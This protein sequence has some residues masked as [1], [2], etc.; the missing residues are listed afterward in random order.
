[1]QEKRKLQSEPGLYTLKRAYELLIEGITPWVALGNFMNDFYG[2]F[3]EKRQELIDEPIVVP[4]NATEEQ[5]R[6]AVFFAASA[7]YHANKYNLQIPEWCQDSMYTEVKEEWVMSVRPSPSEAIR[8]R[9]KNTSPEEFRRRKIY[10]GSRVFA[11]KYEQAV[12]KS[13]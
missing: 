1:M 2:Y 7:E 9:Y 5:L 11:N 10:C 8:E 4:E 12:R 6:W 3:V 13:S